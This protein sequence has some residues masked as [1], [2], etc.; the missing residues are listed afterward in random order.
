MRALRALSVLEIV[1]REN[2]ILNIAEL[3]TLSGLPR[4]TVYRIVDKLVKED[5][6]YRQIGGRGITVGH[7]LLSLAQHIM[8]SDSVRMVRHEILTR[9]VERVGETCNLSVPDGSQMMYLDRV[10]AHWPLRLHMPVGTRVPMHC[11]ANGK[12]FLAY[13]NEDEQREKIASLTLEKQGDNTITEP[14]VLV[15]ELQ[16]IREQGYS[17]D[18]EELFSGMIAVSVPILNARRKMIAGVAVTAPIARMS[19]D[20]ALVHIP[21]LQDA[22]GELSNYLERK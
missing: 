18:N 3:E 9:L 22:A 8:G 7:K 5:Y 14:K 10:E 4:A 6:L 20:D 13:L 17:T 19:I 11:T 12:L 16:K 2:R 15:K 1:S 21:A